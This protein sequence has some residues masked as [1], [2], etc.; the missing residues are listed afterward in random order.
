MQ[1][2]SNTL[3]VHALPVVYKVTCTNPAGKP[4]MYHKGAGGCRTGG[5]LGSAGSAASAVRAAAAAPRPVLAPRPA[6]SAAAGPLPPPGAAA[7]LADA[8]LRHGHARQ[9]DGQ[10]H[11]LRQVMGLG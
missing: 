5:A 6:P 1:C 2:A 8:R 4:Y 10:L 3:L 11:H 7:A 9:R